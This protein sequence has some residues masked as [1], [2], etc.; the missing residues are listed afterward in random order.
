MS[1]LLKSLSKENK[2]IFENLEILKRHHVIFA[3]MHQF[4]WITRFNIYLII[5][6]LRD[7]CKI[8]TSLMIEFPVFDVIKENLKVKHKNLDKLNSSKCDLCFN[9]WVRKFFHLQQDF[10]KKQWISLKHWQWLV[11]RITKIL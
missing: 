5:N 10:T 9:A 6:D 3:Y 2:E 4:L 11:F 8:D 1:V 7:W